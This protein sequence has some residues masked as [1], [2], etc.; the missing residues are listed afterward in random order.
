[1]NKLTLIMNHRLR[2]GERLATDADGSSFANASRG[3]DPR[4]FSYR[5]LMDFVSRYPMITVSRRSK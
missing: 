1:M 2:L 4:A 3:K 5:K